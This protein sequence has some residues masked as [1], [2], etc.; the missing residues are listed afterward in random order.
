MAIKCVLCGSTLAEMFFE[1][2]FIRTYYTISPTLVKWF[3]ETQR[4]KN[5]FKGKLD[6]LVKKLNR[7]GVD[8]TPY[9][10]KKWN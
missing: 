8:N 4:F 2:A 3:G 10:D 1:R 6:A 7:H 9:E 5:L